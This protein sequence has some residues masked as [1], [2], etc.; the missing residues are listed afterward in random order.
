VFDTPGTVA[1]QVGLGDVTA[2]AFRGSY[3]VDFPPHFN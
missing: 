1:W 2:A 3:K